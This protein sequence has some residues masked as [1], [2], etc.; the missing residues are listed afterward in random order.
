M[1]TTAVLVAMKALGMFRA[2]HIFVGRN[3]EAFKLRLQY[4]L[5]VPV[6]QLDRSGTP[7]TM[8]SLTDYAGNVVGEVSDVLEACTRAAEAAGVPR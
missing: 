8:T 4:Q 3:G 2:S 7:Q 6:F 1:Y 5:F